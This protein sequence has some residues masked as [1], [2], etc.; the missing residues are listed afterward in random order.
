MPEYPLG[1]DKSAVL[2]LQ[3][4]VA[5]AVRFAHMQMKE[6]AREKS[7]SKKGEKIDDEDGAIKYEQGSRNKQKKNR[8]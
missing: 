2:V 6:E 7:S 3:E 8:K 5:D 1:R 4:R